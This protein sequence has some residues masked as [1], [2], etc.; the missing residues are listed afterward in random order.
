MEM[1]KSWKI[2]KN[3]VTYILRDGGTNIIKGLRLAECASISCTAHQLNLVV[4]K[5]VFSSSETCEVCMYSVYCLRV[6][7]VT[8]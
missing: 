6:V 1:L 2:E 4:E 3:R 5:A 7:R 8:L